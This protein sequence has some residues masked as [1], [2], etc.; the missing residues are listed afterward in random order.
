MTGVVVNCGVREIRS[1]AMSASVGG[2]AKRHSIREAGVPTLK[3]P[4]CSDEADAS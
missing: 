3:P 1:P 2:R 4:F